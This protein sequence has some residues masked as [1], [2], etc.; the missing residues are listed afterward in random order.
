MSVPHA[1]TL[2]AA[3][4]DLAAHFDTLKERATAM[5]MTLGASERG[6]FRPEE[7]EAVAHLLVSYC[8]SRAALFDVIA[9]FREDEEAYGRPDA[10]LIAFTAALVLVDAARF[11]RES[12]HDRPVVRRK[13]NEANTLF[14][15]PDGVYDA[16]QKSLT[17]PS[18]AI[19][20]LRATSHF[21]ESLDAIRSAAKDSRLADLLDV[22]LRLV[23]RTRVSIASYAKARA[24]VRATQAAGG[25]RRTV[26][27]GLLFVLK[28]IAG[29]LAARF[30]SRTSHHPGL[31]SEVASE[32]GGLLKPGDVLVTRK[33]HRITNY[34][35]PG[36]WP[37]A[38]LYLGEVSELPALG[39][40]DSESERKRWDQ[41]AMP[42]KDP[43]R[44]LEAMKDGVLVRPV[45]SPL[46]ADSI[47]VIRPRL[48]PSDLSIGLARGLAHEGKRYDFDFDFTRA[49]RLVCTEVVYRSFDGLGDLRFELVRRVGRMNFSAAD[50]LEMAIDERGFDTV[51]VFIPGDDS[52]VL[53]GGDATRRVR[54]RLGK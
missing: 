12:F 10:F 22:A 35:L 26:L 46:S 50:L 13:L 39:M 38:A 42:D 40:D 52:R 5:S 27:G 25:L 30:S 31:P 4:C 51:A 9:S 23:D 7:E 19:E 44:V 1:S 16:V 20:I 49:D 34:F 33:E 47:V 37:H 24:G 28:G 18:N 32:L 21:D 14:D 11:L 48:T 53:L 6:Y 15:I 36:W 43:R 3:V 8:K 54:E 45:S 29:E 41:L 17:S 2:A